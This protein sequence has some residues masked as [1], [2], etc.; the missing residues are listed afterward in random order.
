MI[1]PRNWSSPQ[2]PS[3]TAG[4]QTA[5]FKTYRS[6]LTLGLSSWALQSDRS[7][8][9]PIWCAFPKL[10]NASVP[11][12]PHPQSSNFNLHLIESVTQELIHDKLSVNVHCCFYF[13]SLHTQTVC[14]G[15][16]V[17]IFLLPAASTS[18]Y[19]TGGP[20]ADPQSTAHLQRPL[21]V[22]FLNRAPGPQM[23]TSWQI[24]GPSATHFIPAWPTAPWHWPHLGCDKCL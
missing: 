1:H 17:S 16:D 23:S 6:I 3:L 7:C 20:L 2:N 12:C 21:L 22:I 10:Q 15:L 9:F 13:Q 4:F 8:S 24:I 11:H 14:A 19:R 5:T 18:S